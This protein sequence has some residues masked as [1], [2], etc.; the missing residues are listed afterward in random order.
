MA[1]DLGMSIKVSFEKM[2]QN[3]A[4]MAQMLTSLK[5]ITLAVGI[6]AAIWQALEPLLKPVLMIFRAILTMLFLPLIPLLKPFIL[7]MADVMK[8][9]YAAQTATAA[10]GGGPL[11]QFMA[12]L[13]VLLS[14]PSMWAI[15]GGLLAI[16]F[17]KGLGG[18]TIAGAILAALSFKIIWDVLTKGDEK[19]FTEM[20]KTA[21]W[22]GLAAGIAALT[23]GAPS[24][25]P[26]AIGTLVFGLVLGIEFLKKAWKEEDL[27]KAIM[28]AAVGSALVGVVAGGV[29]ALLGMGGIPASVTAISIGT[30]LFTAFVGFRLG[31]EAA[32]PEEDVEKQTGKLKEQEQQIGILQRIWGIFTA[33]VV[34][35]IGMTLSPIGTMGFLIGS[36]SAGSYP[37]V[38]SLNLA[39]VKW[40]TMADTSISAIKSIIVN[41]NQIPR[42]IVTVHRIITV[43]ETAGKR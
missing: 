27:K 12:G 1:E 33:F 3:T 36:A 23:F 42:E 9:M 25:Y 43:Y 24:P 32:R 40:R 8:K 38:Y 13:D 11:E 34:E 29:L 17:L 39:T 16:G 35:N 41:L 2:E 21:G 5:K 6:G 28:E 7:M 22:A 26:L 19:N 20:L 4:I 31:K 30:I 10:A 18:K 15:I 37:I 14:E